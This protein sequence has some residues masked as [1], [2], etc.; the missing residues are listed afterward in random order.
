MKH[1]TTSDSSS[2]LSKF[3]EIFRSLK[4]Q[5]FIA[6]FL[7]GLACCFTMHVLIFN[8]YEERSVDIRATEMQRQLNLLAN[9]L[10][11]Y[12][13]MQDTDDPVINAEIDYLSNFNNGRIIIINDDLKVVMD[14]Y[15]ISLNKHIVSEETIN[16]LKAG[17]RG[18][19]SEYDKENGYLEVVVPIVGTENADGNDVIDAERNE[20]VRG[21]IMLSVSMDPV[22]RLLGKMSKKI[23]VYE[24]LI[25][26]IIL[27]I[28]Y[29]LSQNLMKPFDKITADINE[30]KA[31]YTEDSIDIPK[32]TEAK[33]IAIAFNAL[34]RR[35]KVLDDSRQEFVS[36]VSHELRTPITSMKV[37]AD[38]LL[39]MGEDAPVE[40][41]RD[42]MEDIGKEVDRENKIIGDLLTLVK[43]DKKSPELEITKVDIEALIEGVLKRI[44][45]ISMQ[46]DIEL[47][48]VCKRTVTAEVDEVKISQVI[49][50]LVENAV[51]YNKDGGSVKVI[52]DADHQYFT[53]KVMDSGV[54]IP[55]D[56]LEHVFE[57]FYRVD[58][59]R[60]REIGGTGLGLAISKSAVLMHRGTIDVES[61]LGVGTTFT[62]KIPLIVAT[63]K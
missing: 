22:H 48:F 1:N 34:L 21:A 16:C 54:G 6:I 51:K 14:T 28:A 26:F 23:A 27:C 24:G 11:K 13:Y 37:L 17:S 50:N 63:E 30:V 36:N 4:G 18:A 19:Y 31:G 35:M 8:E 55:E 59:S 9:R 58:K 15:S 41:Y 3:T 42:F 38:S 43:M 60:S 7:T 10:I 5:F 12:N 32:L 20:V 40:L 33:H 52:L 61:K 29:A 45:P 49:T 57:R 56:A 44:K 62:V 2:K 47:V 46:R 25:I 39:S 53:V